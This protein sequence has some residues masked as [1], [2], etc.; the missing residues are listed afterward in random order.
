[1]YLL[2]EGNYGVSFLV[3]HFP[4]CYLCNISKEIT[5]RVAFILKY[6]HWVRVHHTLC[7]I[8]T[9]ICARFKPI[10]SRFGVENPYWKPRYTMR[11]NRCPW[12]MPCLQGAV[13]RLVSCFSIGHSDYLLARSLFLET[14]CAIECTLGHCA[15]VYL[16]FSMAFI[17]QRAQLLTVIIMGKVYKKGIL[18]TTL[19]F[20][21]IR[22][23]M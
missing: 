11:E 4:I 3:C 22:W 7:R 10:S 15:L 16:C 12:H 19:V 17:H 14:V 2:L 1:M 20:F 9:N 8:Y 6:K 18:C 5:N 13:G 23:N 21:I